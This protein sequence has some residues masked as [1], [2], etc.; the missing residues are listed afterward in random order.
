METLTFFRDHLGDRRTYLRVGVGLLIGLLVL[1]MWVVGSRRP[2]TVINDSRQEAG[3]QRSE[4]EMPVPGEPKSITRSPQ[5][6]GSFLAESIPAPDPES[7]PAPD[8]II[9]P[10]LP[11]IGDRVIRTG[12]VDIK[13]KKGGF[14]GA[15][16]RIL[17]LANAN[18]GFVAG[19][20]STTNRDAVFGTVTIRVPAGAFEK[21]VR[22]IKKIGKVRSINVN[23]QD[24]SQEFVDLESRLRH[25]RA[26]E[27]VLLGIM[28][29]TQTIAD[30]IAV[31]NQLAQIQGQIEQITG[32]LNF[33]KNQTDLSTIQ[34]TINESGSTVPQPADKW[35]FRTSLSRAAHAFVDTVNGFVIVMGYILPPAIIVLAVLASIRVVGR[36]ESR[37]KS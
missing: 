11:S 24:V 16:D 9:V 22:E 19:T 17:L 31:Q 13:V 15:Y 1:S 4:K 35:G 29:K 25:L 10:G 33:L 34:V 5:T 26:Q 28:A 3:E 7:M 18:G 20:N 30:S 37:A 23:S 36:R 32:R 14:D 27:Q 8:Q 12:M 6:D 2:L 21:V